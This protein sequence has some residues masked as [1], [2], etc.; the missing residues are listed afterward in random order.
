[1]KREQRAPIVGMAEVWKAGRS[2]GHAQICNLSEGGVGVVGAFYGATGEIVTVDLNGIGKTRGKVAWVGDGTFGITFDKPIDPDRFDF[3][4]P[5]RRDHT[6]RA[7]PARW[8]P[9]G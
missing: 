4:M 9:A 2:L 6:G 5:I 3:S 7:I 8:R 1:M